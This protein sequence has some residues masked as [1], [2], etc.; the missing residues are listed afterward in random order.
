MQATSVSLVIPFYNEAALLQDTVERCLALQGRFD[1]PLELIF[2]DDGSRDRGPEIARRFAGRL[3]LVSY[4]DNRGKGHAVRRG[5]LASAGVSHSGG[6]S[7]GS[8]SPASSSARAAR[9]AALD[10][11]RS[12][13]LSSL[14]N[15]REIPPF[16]G[17]SLAQRADLFA[18]DESI[19]F[20]AAEPPGRTHRVHAEQLG[21]L[22]GGERER[23]VAGLPL[24]LAAKRHEQAE[25]VRAVEIRCRGD[26]LGRTFHN[27]CHSAS[28]AGV[29]DLAPTLGE[30]VPVLVCVGRHDH[31]I[32]LAGGGVPRVDVRPQLPD[33]AARQF[34]VA[35]ERRGEA[36]DAFVAFPRCTRDRAFDG[37]FDILVDPLFTLWS[38]CRSSGCGPTLM[39]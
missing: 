30:I 11:L 38:V 36:E 29:S 15:R 17:L 6:S 25:R 21:H 2:V 14:I 10:G 19:A 24:Q 18:L 37:F 8:G 28:S 13:M 1:C 35:L 5:V 23:L 39:S 9:R 31:A 33:G 32:H 34:G 27:R 16:R 26:R 12:I 20:D 7:A 4:P 3:R 22:P